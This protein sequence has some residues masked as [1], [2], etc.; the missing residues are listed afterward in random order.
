AQA[1]M[2]LFEMNQLKSDFLATVSHELRTPLNSIIGFS[3]LLSTLDNLTEKELRYA[4]NI[5]R[6]GKQLLEMINDIL[7]LAKIESGKMEVRA[8]DC[9]IGS[10]V[11]AQCDMARPLSEKKNIDLEC[12]IEPGLPLMR[13]DQS[14]I[15]QI[16]NNLLSNAIKFTPDGGRITIHV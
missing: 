2:R 6:S 11:A 16:L 14:K 1:N 10:V 9:N 15:E 12:Q 4:V 8:G 13:Q 7:D 3:D 5:Q